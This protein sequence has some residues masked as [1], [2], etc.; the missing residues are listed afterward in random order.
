VIGSD[1]LAA[2]LPVVEALEQVGARYHVGGSV[3]SSAM[4]IARSTLDVDLVADLRLAQVDGLVSAL[5]RDYYIDGDMICDAIHRRSCFNVIHLATMLKVD[6]FVLKQRPYDLLAFSRAAPAALE[7]EPGAR[8]YMLASPEDTILNKLEWY[9][10]GG[11]VSDRQWGDVLGV[12]RVR[13]EVLDL[14][15]L[16]RWATEIGVAA[17]LERALVEAGASTGE[18]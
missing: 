4:G 13:G 3:A 17:L 7:E 16:R 14:A 1:I 11:R 18:P 8:S 2:M 5:E 10:L 6:V 9:E 12:L 15:Y